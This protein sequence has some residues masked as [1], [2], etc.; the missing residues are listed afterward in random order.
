MATPQ[1]KLAE[2]LEVL[3]ALQDRGVVAI[4][5]ADLKRVHRERLFKNGFLQEV[6]KGW[7]IATH[8]DYA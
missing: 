7:Y 1:E 8:P 5:A 6:M 4:R 2:S 3:R